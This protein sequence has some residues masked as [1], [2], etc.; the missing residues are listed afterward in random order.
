MRQARWILA[1]VAATALVAAGCSSSDGGS[2]DGENTGPGEPVTLDF[3]VFK[4]IESGAFY[5]TLISDFEATHPNIDIELTSYPE[6][7]Y[8]VKVDTAIAAGKEPDLVLAFGPE[9]IRSRLLMPIDDVLAEQGIDLSTYSQSILGEGGEFS[10]GWEGRLYCMGSYQGVFGV[11]YNKSMLDAAGIPY[12]AVWPPM[13]PDEFV[14][15]A[16][17]L[18][19]EP[20]GV[21]GGAVNDPMN[22]LPWET[23]VSDDGR[24]VQ[25]SVNGPETVHTFD[26]L[27]QGYAQHCLPSLNVLD[28]SI[29]GRDFI[30]EGSLAMALTDLL[31][32]R[33]LEDAGID[34]GVT[35]PPT[36]PGEDP[37]FFSWS[38]SVGVMNTTDS[39]EAA[40]AFIAFLATD[41]GRIR[42]ETTGDLPLD[43]TVAEDVNWANDIPG[44][45]DIL[46]LATHARPAIF[47]PNRWDALGPLWDAWGYVTSG[48]KTAQAA[49]DDVTPAIQE[50]LDKAWENW[51]E[52]G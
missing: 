21:W 2:D 30:A 25:G 6:E 16:C 17:R 3:W 14:D 51:E 37:Y 48:E 36:P 35:A 4:E 29:Q 27:S 45:L 24:S 44:R 15:M 26:V 1:L 9:D 49:L 19:D 31:D 41:G 13:T 5:D 12:P 22:F 38:D 28:P 33:T 39:P 40:K 7:G 10:C 18:T 8:G 50:N 20:A 43:S 34:Y 47:I 11:V 42:F 52:Q 23:Y 32:L 46:E